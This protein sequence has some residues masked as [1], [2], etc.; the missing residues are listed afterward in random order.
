MMLS[1][2]MQSIGMKISFCKD[3]TKRNSN[4]IVVI[5]MTEIKIVQEA[6]K[7]YLEKYINNFKNS[8]IRHTS[9]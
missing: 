2:F 3:R 6:Y 8:T 5:L 4:L 1:K 7:R 9:Q